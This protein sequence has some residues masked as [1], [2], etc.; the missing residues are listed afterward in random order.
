MQ[1]EDGRMDVDLSFD[2]TK[3]NVG[4]KALSIEDDWRGSSCHVCGYGSGLFRSDLEIGHLDDC[5]ET[6]WT[7]VF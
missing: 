7:N 3:A 6:I 5:L 1:L 2:H 4:G